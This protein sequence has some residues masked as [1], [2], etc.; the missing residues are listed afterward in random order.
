M[1]KEKLIVRH[2]CALGDTV[3]LTALLRDIEKTYPGRFNVL[4]DANVRE[5]LVGNPYATPAT[6]RDLNSTAQS[7]TINYQSGIVSAQQGTK[8]HM[9]RS[10]HDDFNAKTGLNV[11]VT[12]PRPD[13]RLLD[14]NLKPIVEGD[15]WLVVAGSKVDVTI[16][17]WRSTLWQKVVDGLQDRGIRVV[18]AGATFN[19]HQNPKLT[20]VIDLVGKYPDARHLLNLV[21]YARGVICP[22][23]A[24]M[25]I[26]AAFET[27]CVVVAGGREEPWWEGY[28][29]DHRGS[30]G[31][32]APKI[33]VE[34]KYLHTIGFM[35]CCRAR[36]CWKHRVRPLHDGARYDA[37]EKLCTH[38]ALD[39]TAA[40]CMDRVTPQIVL[41]AVDEYLA[42]PRTVVEK[43]VTATEAVIRLPVIQ[44]PEIELPRD[45]DLIDHPIIG[46]KITAFV[47]C[48]GAYPQLARDC[49]GSIIR[50][51]PRNR[52]DL[53]VAL[54]D[55][56]PETQ[57]YVRSVEPTA[58]YDAPQNPGKYVL[59]R[60]MFNDADHPVTTPYL[61]W[62]DDDATI[63]DPA[64]WSQ[65]FGTIVSNHPYG[66]RMYGTLMSHDLGIYRHHDARTWFRDAPWYRGRNFRIRGTQA[67]TP[68]GTVIP[69]A[70]GWFW[71]M[72]TSLI[73]SADIPCHRLRHNGGDITIGS[74]V[75]QIGAKIKQFNPAKSLVSCPSRE[76]G[77]RRGQSH[78]FPWSEL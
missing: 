47:L 11:K 65:L 13:L 74:Q 30:F 24:A 64:M 51:I 67:E 72:H 8:I 16:K 54:A 59:M 70:V 44:K 26:A 12:L 28:N 20:G 6:L 37:I 41:A 76:N 4:V 17:Q 71:S 1:A 7:V 43:P 35:D 5:V 22:I 52:L 32:I 78:P 61:A 77:G 21:K 38:P 56:C 42:K 55:A 31:E 48:Y 60:Q 50:T 2:K 66:S 34:H 19:R 29:N 23:T 46:G 69:F 14:D 39:G 10:F 75:A 3:V 33:A 49:I 36:G 58:V 18:Q 27:P 63:V 45:P 9:L 25:H 62:F 68:E 73:Q 57:A 40:Q 53:R 15:Y